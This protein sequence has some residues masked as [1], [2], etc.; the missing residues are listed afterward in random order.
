MLIQNKISLASYSLSEC[1][2]DS[3]I[4]YLQAVTLLRE[5]TDHVNNTA[6]ELM[7]PTLRTTVNTPFQNCSSKELEGAGTNDILLSEGVRID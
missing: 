1:E 7:K 3:K 5:S 6:W 4:Q 2:K